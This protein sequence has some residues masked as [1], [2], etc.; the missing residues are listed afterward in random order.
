MSDEKS[1]PVLRSWL[2][3][4]EVAPPDATQSVAHVMT[5]VPRTRQRG[6]WWPL[7]V[8]G[9]GSVAPPAVSSTA[10]QPTP[11]PSMHGHTLTT[12]GRTH[13]MFSP[14][15][16]I[17]AGALVFAL[18]GVLL[19]SQPFNQQGG[20]VPGAAPGDAEVTNETLFELTIPSAALPDDFAYF[21]VEDLTLAADT[22]SIDDYR[23][24][25]ANES[26]RGRAF[27]VESGEFLFEPT[28]DALLWPG[29]GQAPQV[30]PAG[31]AVTVRPG[32][33]IFLPAMADTEVDGENYLRI[34]NPGSEDATARSFHTC[35]LTPFGGLASGLS[36]GDWDEGG[37][38]GHLKEP[39][40][41]V[42]VLF[43]LTRWSG[44][45]GAALPLVDPPAV[46]HYFVES[47][48][49]ERTVSR[50]GGEFTDEWRTGK[51]FFPPLFGEVEQTLAVMGDDTASVLVLV[52]IPM[53]K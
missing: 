24:S 16:A 21:V 13:V 17:T 19:I 33:A 14:A 2:K 38:F 35:D 28:T 11:I 29:S 36:I 25:Q 34:A 46:A 10:L 43:R 40:A 47:G 49:L 8:F 32:E 31:E 20:S 41:G 39:F 23:T 44:G 48:T 50:P 4:R 3:T 12:T 22:V 45:P 6:H 7:P 18:G 5:Q 37:Y 52:A 27:L 15:K 26:M 30:A 9:R 53:S 51:D 42:D 1:A